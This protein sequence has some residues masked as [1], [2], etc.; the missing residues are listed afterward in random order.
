MP[1]RLLARC[2]RILFT[3]RYPLVIAFVAAFTLLGMTR[4][5]EAYCNLDEGCND[6]AEVCFGNFC[7]HTWNYHAYFDPS[8]SGT[9][10]CLSGPCWL[11]D[12]VLQGGGCEFC[13][14]GDREKCGYGAGC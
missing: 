1:D 5:S 11:L 3:L 9:S 6:S 7:W 10:C 2:E 12:D 14:S 4:Y 8:C 13:S